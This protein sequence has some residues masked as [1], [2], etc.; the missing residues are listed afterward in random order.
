[1]HNCGDYYE[2]IAVYIDDL[3]IVSKDLQSLINALTQKHNFKLKGTGPIAFHL[4]CNF[5]HDEDGIMCM[6][7]RKYIKKMEDNYECMFGTKPKTEYSLP[8]DKGD[9]PELDMTDFLNDKDTQQYQSLVGTMQWAVSL[10][11]INITTA[12][13]TLSSFHTIPHVGHID[14]TKCVC[15][16]LSKMKQAIICFCTDEPN[17][18]FLLT[19]EYDWTYTVYGDICKVTPKDA[20]EPL[21]NFVTLTHYFDVNLMH[22]LLTRCSI[23]GILHL[24]NK[25]PNNWFSKK[26]ATIKT[27][28]YGS[29]FVAA[30]TCVKQVINLCDTF[31]YL[32]IP[33][34]DKGYMFGDNK[35]MIDSG[36]IPHSKLHKHH[37]ALSYHY[38]REAIA[39]SIV[40]LHHLPGTSNPADILSKHWGYQQVWKLLHPLLFWQGDTVDVLEL[41]SLKEG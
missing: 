9:H 21:G 20:L 11:C 13:M 3:A 23:T 22:D 37:V 39:A 17:Y 8:L 24:A 12:I 38:V 4:G 33:V 16:Y 19:N 31:C 27:A 5:F 28:T 15:G 25:T 32:S 18:S 36:T 41:M 34:H 6:A 7:P 26:Q 35:S 1:M 2:Y 14:C 40:S 30:C 29:E 10:G